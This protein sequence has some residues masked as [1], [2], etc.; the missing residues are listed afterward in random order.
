MNPKT[1]TN[2]PPSITFF[3]EST[4]PWVDVPRSEWAT[5]FDGVTEVMH[6]LD[7]HLYVETAEGPD[8]LAHDAILGQI[9][10]E[11]KG[12]EANTVEIAL[13]RR[14]SVYSDFRFTHRLKDPVKVAMRRGH[15]PEVIDLAIVTA[16]QR[17]TVIELRLPDEP[18][19][20]LRKL[21]FLKSQGE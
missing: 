21:A 7:C 14:D 1:R 9:S 19:P 4:E 13:N 16:D 15:H 2:L 12:S 17:R 8:F 5:T 6:D 10:F 18:A 11:T 20:G 3:P